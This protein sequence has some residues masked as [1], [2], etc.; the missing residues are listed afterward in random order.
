MEMSSLT[1]IYKGHNC[2]N[3]AGGNYENPTNDAKGEDE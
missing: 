2:Q 3:P 1:Y